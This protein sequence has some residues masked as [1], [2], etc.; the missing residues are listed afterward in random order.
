[1]ESGK[2]KQLSKR[3]ITKLPL[4]TFFLDGKPGK[5]LSN[6]VNKADYLTL[7][8]ELLHNLM[9]EPPRYWNL[10]IPIGGNNSLE[11][12]LEPNDILSPDFVVSNSAQLKKPSTQK[13]FL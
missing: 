13:S 11:L 3:V 2:H 5:D 1:M 6:Y 12:E 9:A 8:K 7:N 4:P 10:Q